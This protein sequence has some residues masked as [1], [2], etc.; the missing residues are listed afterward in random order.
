MEI[1]FPMGCRLR[2]PCCKV[3]WIKGVIRTF[4]LWCSLV[5]FIVL[6]ARV[7]G[8]W[9]SHVLFNGL[10]LEVCVKVQPLSR[11]ADCGCAWV[12][13]GIGVYHWNAQLC[14]SPYPPLMSCWCGWSEGY[15]ASCCCFLS[16]LELFV[17]L[18]Q[19][20]VVWDCVVCGPLIA[21]YEWNFGAKI[22]LW[23]GT[24]KT[25]LA[26]DFIGPVNFR[27]ELV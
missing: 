1:S 15:F 19:S 22:S 16:Q 6:G 27:L 12:S 25:P 7:L 23:E 8:C 13:I 10:A 5:F 20:I 9:A 14:F 26:Q 18:I 24:G 4:T 21:W 3:V 2:G 11:I 17:L